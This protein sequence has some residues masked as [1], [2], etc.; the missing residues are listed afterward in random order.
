[1][2]WLVKS[3]QIVDPG[4]KHHGKKR[5]LLIEDGVITSIKASIKDSKAEKIAFTNLH[6]SPGW[7]DAKV[8]FRDPGSE[9]KEGLLNGLDA[10]ACGGFTHVV[11]MPST[12][13]V[14]DN[15]GQI[16]Y[17]LHRSDD[18]LVRI[19]PTGK[20]S[21]GGEGKQLAELYDMFKAGAVAFSEDGPIARGE[22][23]RRALEYSKNFGGVI[24]STPQEESIADKGVMHEGLTSTTN[25]LKGIPSM[26][27]IIRLKRDIE[28]LRYTGGSLHVMSI[29]CGESVKIIKEAKKE[30]LAITCGVAAHHL[31]FNDTDLE[32]FDANLKVMPPIRSKQDQKALLKG[33]KEGTIDVICSDHQ[34]EDIEHKKLEFEIANFGIGAIEQTFAAANSLDI[35]L[36]T[37][38]SKLTVA[39]RAVFNLEPSHIEEGAQA[40]ITFFDPTASEAVTSDSLTSLAWNN[41]YISH[42]LTGKVQGVVL[43]GRTVLR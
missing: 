33:V 9:E 6:A 25:G 43:G 26:V 7:I 27:E 8:N 5:D 17:V 22:L 15:K 31:Y 2:R 29:S 30:G 19:L 36:D 13:P 16:E 12:S 37:L 41:P 39:P 3:A 21:K 32:G 28:L 42:T 18:H 1:M 20:I 34:P 23:M 35:E 14:I 10:A 38:I 40:D 4:G 24:C 11:L